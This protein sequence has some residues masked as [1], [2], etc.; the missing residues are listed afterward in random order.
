MKRYDLVWSV[1]GDKIDRMDEKPDGD[2]VLYS[3][4][5]SDR[6]LLEEAVKIIENAIVIST[7]NI[8]DFLT[9]AKERGIKG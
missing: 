7:H 8:N 3:D 9:R 1:D 6:A 4:I 2:Y 5:K